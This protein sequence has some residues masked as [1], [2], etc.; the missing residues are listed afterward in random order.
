MHK[1]ARPKQIGRKEATRLIRKGAHALL[2]RPRVLL[3]AAVAETAPADPEIEALLDEYADVF[4][5]CLGFHLYDLL[6]IQYLWSRGCNLSFGLCI[7]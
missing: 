5:R 4:V 3:N 6:I 2:V 7:G 1:S